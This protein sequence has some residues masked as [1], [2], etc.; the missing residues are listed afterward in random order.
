MNLYAK[1]KMAMGVV[2]TGARVIASWI[3]QSNQYIED[4]NLFTASMGKYAE[5]AQNYAEAVSEALGID[6]GEV[7]AKS[8]CVQHHH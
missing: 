5:E 6:P 2:R 8:R 7:H 1:I 4:L 3:K